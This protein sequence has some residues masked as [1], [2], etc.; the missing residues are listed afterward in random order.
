MISIYRQ[1]GMPFKKLQI[2]YMI[3]GGYRLAFGNW[4]VYVGGAMGASR[5]QKGWLTRRAADL[6]QACRFLF[7]KVS[8]ASR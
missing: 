5:W 4:L 8:G 1:F 7:N 2:A 3:G 6:R